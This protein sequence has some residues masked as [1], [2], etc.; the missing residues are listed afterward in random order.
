MPEVGP[1][2][3]LERFTLLTRGDV[4]GVVDIVDHEVASLVLAA[5]PSFP[6]ELEA[7]KARQFVAAWQ[8]R[9]NLEAQLYE[10]RQEQREL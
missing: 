7:E 9:A 1:G 2:L 3:G 8:Q 10:V 4:Y 5:L 6:L